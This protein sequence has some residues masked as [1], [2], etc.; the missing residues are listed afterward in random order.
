MQLDGKFIGFVAVGDVVYF[1]AFSGED[2]AVV[3]CPADVDSHRLAASM[4]G[5]INILLEQVAAMSE[6]KL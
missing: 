3:F 5:I 6:Y 4:N 1:R 2:L